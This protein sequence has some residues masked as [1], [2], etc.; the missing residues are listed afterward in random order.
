MD[1]DKK[2]PSHRWQLALFIVMTV[3][4]MAAFVAV[5]VGMVMTARQL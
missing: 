5:C 4:V 2:P 1:T 3:L